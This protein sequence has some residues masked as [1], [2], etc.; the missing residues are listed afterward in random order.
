MED[1]VVAEVE[2]PNKSVVALDLV[3]LGVVEGVSNIEEAASFLVAGVSNKEDT[4]VVS[5]FTVVVVGASNIELAAFDV[6]FL[7]VVVGASNIED[8][9][10]FLVA[11]VSNKED[12]L[13]VSFLVVVGA[14]NIEEVEVAAAVSFLVVVG[15][16]NIELAVSFLVEGASNR[17]D[18]VVVSFFTVVVVGASNIEL[19][20]VSFLEEEGASNTE[21]ELAVVEVFLE[22]GASNTEEEEEEEVDFLESFVDFDFLE[23]GL[24]P[25]ADTLSFLTSFNIPASSLESVSSLPLTDLESEVE[26]EFEVESSESVDLDLGGGPAPPNILIGSKAKLLCNFLI[27]SDALEDF[28][29]SS[30]ESAES[31]VLVGVV[32][33]GNI[34]TPP[35]IPFLTLGLSPP[36]GSLIPLIEY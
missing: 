24:L 3:L 33:G 30:L 34:D 2:E 17:D 9:V 16:S 4:V 36:S 35:T 19:A 14:S 7:V 25:L 18:A 26:S 10:S 12:A 20:V 31:V 15:A 27:L 32:T 28:L 11:V 1:V 5:F 22:E 23:G 21:V 13:V 29:E 8:A 6:S